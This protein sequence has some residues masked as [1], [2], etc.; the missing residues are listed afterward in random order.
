MGNIK[1]SIVVPVYNV[2]K[3]LS[4]CLDTLINQTLKEI[5]IICVNDG[6][7]DSSETILKAYQIKDPRIKIINQ[8]NQG[9]SGARNTGIKAATGEYIGLIDS[10][11]WVDLDFYEKLYNA[12]KKYDSDIAA[13]DFYRR[14]KYIK[15][16]KLKYKKE[17]F[18]T[19]AAEK[20][21]QAF[22]PKYNYVWNKI[23]KRESLEK[24]NYPFPVG[25]YYEDMYWLVKVVYHLY[26]F[27]TV[28]NTFYHYRRTEGSIITQK[29][30]KHLEDCRFAEIEMLKFMNKHNIPVLV[31]C[32]MYKRATVKL[33]GLKIL[34]IENYYPD[35]TVYKLFGFINVLRIERRS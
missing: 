8:E 20:V 5:E 25:R 13:G 31:S 32:K 33:F 11:D 2:E 14:G 29:S 9:L 10:D 35:T 21:K 1:V 12:A 34:K 3:Y 23:Y 6:S 18:F 15:T 4:Q 26:G 16:Q 27:V 22:I 28:P 7:K 24:M 17:A 30:A 19:E